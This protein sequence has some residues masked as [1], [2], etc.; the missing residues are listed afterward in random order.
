MVPF[1]AAI[2]ALTNACGMVSVGTP[3]ARAVSL[4]ARID[5]CS[6]A[7]GG[8]VRVPQGRYEDML[9]IVLKD[10]VELHLEAGVVLQATT[11]YDSYVN[12]PGWNRG[13]FITALGAT[14]IAITG[15]GQIECSGDR[16]GDEYTFIGAATCGLSGSPSR[17]RIPGA[18]TCTNATA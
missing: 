12:M 18:A 9:P 17:T 8:V 2:V 5:A 3:D 11:N 10:N 1:L 15:E 7:G 4:Q 16:D 6:A 13:A 14:N